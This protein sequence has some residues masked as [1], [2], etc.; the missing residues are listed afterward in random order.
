MP[1]HPGEGVASSFHSFC[2]LASLGPVLQL[3]ALT[4]G[5]VD[6]F[7]EVERAEAP[8]VPGSLAGS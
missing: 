6:G 7:Y 8:G 5:H 2:L 4:E 1:E 3:S